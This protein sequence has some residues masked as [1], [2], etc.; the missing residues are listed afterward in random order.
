MNK[1]IKLTLMKVNKVKI[2]KHQFIILKIYRWVG[3]ANLYLTGCI[4]C[5]D[6]GFNINVKFVGILVIGV[7]ELFK[8]IFKNGGILMV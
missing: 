5:M 4:N 8:C 1:L 7:E 6:L 3:M 2:N